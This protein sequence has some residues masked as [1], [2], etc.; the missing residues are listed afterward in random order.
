MKLTLRRALARR[1]AALILA[2]ATAGAATQLIGQVLYSSIVGTV[3]DAS[4]S[5]IVKAAVRVTNT[6]TNQSRDTA[7]NTS[8]DY[9]FPSLSPGTY[10]VKVSISGFQGPAACWLSAPQAS[11]CRAMHPLCL[12]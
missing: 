7:T 1:G 6:E 11:I 3:R 2:N 8:G 12:L 5:A 4:G 10:D 9:A